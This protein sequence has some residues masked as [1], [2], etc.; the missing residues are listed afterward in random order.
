MASATPNQS[1]QAKFRSHGLKLGGAF[2]VAALL[3]MPAVA[4]KK[5]APLFPNLDL[6]P[7][8]PGSATSYAPASR[9]ST[10]TPADKSDSALYL[11]AKLV[12]DGDPISS[13]L[14]WRV[15]V[16]TKAADGKLELVATSTGGD[17]EFRLKPGSYLVHAAYGRAG[18]TVRVSVKSKLRTETLVLNAGGLKLEGVVGREKPIAA[19]NVDFDVFTDV[20]G[21]DGNRRPILKGVKPGRIV[22]LNA[23]TYHVVS[24]F[25]GVNAVRRADIEVE[26]GK[27]TE[28][29]IFH[30]AARITLKLV[31]EPGGEALAD[32]SW[33]VLTPGGDIVVESVGAFPD[34][35]LAEGE[36]SVIAKHAG[37][38]F[39]RDF[40][41]E[42]A[43][44]REVEVLMLQKRQQ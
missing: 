34:F 11:V 16:E 17:A 33:S 19:E 4:Q 38:V 39:N 35:V 25:G 13:G 23:G 20:F 36:Y 43:L 15:F 3:A 2:I 42:A 37:E 5:N 32:T 44:D 7:A 1:F 10:G 18:A 6:N 24:R 30:E 14:V 9:P 28:A 8:K 31:S 27:L 21:G 40:S 26:A 12:D 41:V 22:R 29:T